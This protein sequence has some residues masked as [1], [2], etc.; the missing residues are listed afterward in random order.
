MDYQMIKKEISFSDL[1]DFFKKNDV[2]TFDKEIDEFGGYFITAARIAAVIIAPDPVTKIGVFCAGIDAA[3]LRASK[4]FSWLPDKF[5]YK[6]REKTALQKYELASYVNFILLQIAIKNGVKE[7][8]M[9]HL[10]TVLNHIELSD[11]DKAELE[12]K[13]K[14]CDKEKD[15][16]SLPA[17]CSLSREDISTQANKIIDPIFSVLNR[18]IDKSKETTQALNKIDSSKT[19]E[20]F[21]ENVSLQYQAFLINFSGEFPEFALWAD[22]TQKAKILKELKSKQ[23]VSPFEHPQYPSLQEATI[24]ELVDEKWGWEQLSVSEYNEYLEVE[25]Y[26]AHIGQFIHKGAKLDELRKELS[27]I[28]TL[29][30]IT[31]EDGK[32]TPLKVSVHHSQDQLLEVHNTL[33]ALHRKYEQRVNYFKAKV[34]NLITEENAR[35]SRVNADEQAKINAANKILLLEYDKA[36][37]DFQAFNLEAKQHFEKTRQEEIQKVAALRI[38]VDTRFQPVIDKYLKQLE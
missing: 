29:E 5:K 7:I 1:V 6:D 2:P 37:K 13:S 35:I 18:C 20:I 17:N 14:A 21:I 26:A 30:W 36:V 32:K 12:K 9:P 28:K 10:E 15:S 11:D 23:F 22:T 33:A 3:S 27:T 19:K 38:D 31:I 16:L 34:K 4:L 8:I 25:A 24:V